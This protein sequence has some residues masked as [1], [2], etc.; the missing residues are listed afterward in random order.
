M[1]KPGVLILFLFTFS[2]AHCALRMALRLLKIIEPYVVEQER[3]ANAQLLRYAGVHIRYSLTSINHTQGHKNFSFCE[4]TLH[5]GLID[6]SCNWLQSTRKNRGQN[7]IL[8][9]LRAK[10][11]FSEAA[12]FIVTQHF[13]IQ[14]TYNFKKCATRSTK[15]YILR[16]LI[17]IQISALVRYYFVRRVRGGEG[18]GEG[19]CPNKSR[20]IRFKIF[21]FETFYG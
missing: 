16:D 3:M 19:R 8:R 12:I 6:A 13:L 17:S 4:H 10:I 2:I 9:K 14:S 18:H 7:K 11:Q 5:K 1:A 20:G 21:V 15:K